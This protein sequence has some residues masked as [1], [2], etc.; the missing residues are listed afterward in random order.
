ML[1]RPYYPFLVTQ[2]CLTFTPSVLVLLPTSSIKSS[3][4]N[5]ATEFSFSHHLQPASFDRS[6]LHLHSFTGYLTIIISS[7]SPPHPIFIRQVN[8]ERRSTSRA[9][10]SPW[11]KVSL[12][13][14]P[15]FSFPR[16]YMMGRCTGRE[17]STRPVRRL[18]GSAFLIRIALVINGNICRSDLHFVRAHSWMRSLTG[19]FLPRDAVLP[20]PGTVSSKMDSGVAWMRMQ[21]NCMA[22]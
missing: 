19:V 12:V 3:N 1:T 7:L 8:A 5:L 20:L 13:A 16:S 2:L 11:E 22:T 9:T 4:V 6:D 18:S 21:I 14:A 15:D 17:R 10:A